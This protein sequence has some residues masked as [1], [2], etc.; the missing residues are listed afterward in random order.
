MVEYLTTIWDERC[1][2]SLRRAAGKTE[3]DVLAAM[4]MDM[5]RRDSEVDVEREVK[6]PFTEQGIK[7][8]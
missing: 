1:P 8:P 3:N 2:D 6:M 5:H 4:D 7:L